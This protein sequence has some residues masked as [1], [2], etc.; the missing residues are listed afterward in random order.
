MF[1]PSAFLAFASDAK[2]W[3]P[4]GKG[5]DGRTR[6][7]ACSKA[8]VLEK[9]VKLFREHLAWYISHLSFSNSKDWV[10]TA[11]R[12]SFHPSQQHARLSALEHN[13]FARRSSR[14]WTVGLWS[15]C[16]AH[17]RGN[18]QVQRA[19][20][21]SFRGVV[22]LSCCA[23]PKPTLGMHF[24]TKMMLPWSD[25]SA[26]ATGRYL[27]H[28]PVFWQHPRN[29]VAEYGQRLRTLA[30]RNAAAPISH[31]PNRKSPCNMFPGVTLPNRMPTTRPL[32]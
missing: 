2:R 27:Q 3:T 8:N 31:T 7:A 25:D 18:V 24:Q 22:K 30:S 17:P 19:K 9:T 15:I 23:L 1:F 12:C 28:A 11:N 10:A 29:P 21:S 4:T 20:R 26:P 16:S 5:N 32:I 13:L 14:V 6:Q